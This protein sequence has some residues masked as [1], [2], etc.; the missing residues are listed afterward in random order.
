ML[1]PAGLIQKEDFGDSVE[2]RAKQKV[3][4]FKCGCRYKQN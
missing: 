3:A 1:F 4:S 2:D